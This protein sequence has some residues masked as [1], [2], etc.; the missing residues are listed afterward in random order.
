[1]L[2]EREKCCADAGVLC[3]LFV[4]IAGV[5]IIIVVLFWW[6]GIAIADVGDAGD[7]PVDMEFADECG[8][9]SESWIVSDRM[10]RMREE[11]SDE[12][13]EIAMLIF[14]AHKSFVSDGGAIASEDGKRC[15]GVDIV[16]LIL[17]FAAACAEA[18][19]ACR[20]AVAERGECVCDDI[21]LCLVVAEGR[22][23]GEV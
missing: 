7:A 16:F 8:C 14:Y 20:L 1:M 22:E 13:I 17:D 9:A 23:V 10:L 15:V 12:A 4:C 19:K 6:C 3:C 11:E 5:V 21:G 2:S 18:D